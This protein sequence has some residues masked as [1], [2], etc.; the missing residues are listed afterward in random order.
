MALN[1][2]AG[3]D[4]VGAGGEIFRQVDRCQG[5]G[6]TGMP[7]ERDPRWVGRGHFVV[8]EVDRPAVHG[9]GVVC[10]DEPVAADHSRLVGLIDH[11]DPV[12][13]VAERVFLYPVAPDARRLETLPG[14]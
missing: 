8:Q 7:G 10:V 11:A 13:Y 4:V 14:H 12:L 6:A 5:E 1:P 9:D 3:N 2:V